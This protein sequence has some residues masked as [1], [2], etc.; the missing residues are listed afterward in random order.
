M[1][2]GIVGLPNVGKSTLFNALTAAG[3]HSANYPFA[4]VEPNIGVVP[5]PD[6]RLTILNRHVET[7]KVV[8][9]A[10]RVVDIAGLVQ[11]ASKGEGL[12]NRFLSHVRDTDAV[13]QVV[14][15]FEDSPGGEEITHVEGSIDPLRDIETIE[16]ELILADL[17]TVETALKKA[18]RAARGREE[19]TLLRLA[20]L[21]KLQPVLAQGLP[22]RKAD[23][24]SDPRTPEVMKGLG[25]ITTKKQMFVMNVSDDDVLGEGELA[26]QV[27]ALAEE[28]G[29]QAVPVCARIEEELSE[30]DEDDRAEMLE[31]YGMNE[32]ALSKLAH[33]IYDLL[34]LQSFYT[35]GPKEIRA[36]TVR[37]G[38]TAHQAAGVIHTD[39]QRG[40]I[41][42]EVHS[43]D[44]LDEYG[45]EKAIREAGKLRIEGKDYLMQDADVCHFLFN[46]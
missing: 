34:G 18:T 11:G 17:Q 32:P 6:P 8:P 25:L 38:Y 28:R 36:W 46:V 3:A 12:G 29:S 39:F 43:V 23:L 44:E 40:F 15:C 45:S 37:Q 21:E 20:A 30:L 41:R 1:E 31:H 22:A 10:L 27:R 24:G 7:Q 42:V 35:I 2:A 9:T 13:I 5:I 33:A 26:Q 4:T 16:I 14:R 19:D